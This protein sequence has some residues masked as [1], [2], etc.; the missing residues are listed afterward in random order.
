MQKKNNDFHS[1][2]ISPGLQDLDKASEACKNA[3]NVIAKMRAKFSITDSFYR[4]GGQERIYSDTE[5][6]AEL[7]YAETLLTRAILTFFS[8]ESLTSFVRGAFRI[9]A[10][11]QSYKECQRL[12]LCQT[13]SAGR[14]ALKSQFE[15]GTRMGVGT[16]NLLLSTLP[17]RI[18]RLLEVVGFSG[19][20]VTNFF[21]QIYLNSKIAF[22]KTNT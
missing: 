17:S 9:R 18:L 6:H 22:K 11:Y 16:F 12:L 10:C 19:D 7:C 8:D 13:W 15:S 1:I 20:K 5:M 4:I 2:E 14:E 21:L 3:S